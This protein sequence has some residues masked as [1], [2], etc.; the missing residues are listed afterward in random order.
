[1]SLVPLMRG[2]AFTHPPVYGEQTT[3]EVSPFVRPDQQV[4]PE[5]K[6]Y[7]IISQ[8]G[9]KLIYNR[10]YYNF[11]LFDLKN[12]P[13]EVRNLYDH[14]TEKAAE[15]KRR[16]GRFIDVVTVSRPWDADEGQY[17]FGPTGEAREAK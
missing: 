6:K 12:D 17:V 4:D 13:S 16:L 8:D 3:Q 15:M 7:M 9:F 5:F 10:D 14:M 2:E 11:E 1:M